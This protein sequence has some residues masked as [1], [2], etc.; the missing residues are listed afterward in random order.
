[1][2]CKERIQISPEIA[3][4]AD[5]INQ[6]LETR[7]HLKTLTVSGKE[8]TV[9]DMEGFDINCCSPVLLNRF[10][11]NYVQERRRI[12][13]SGEAILGHETVDVQF[14]QVKEYFEAAYCRTLKDGHYVLV[15]GG[16][17][18]SP[19]IRQ[20]HKEGFYREIQDVDRLAFEV[21]DPAEPEKESEEV[22]VHN[23]LGIVVKVS[24]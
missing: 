8:E 12:V 9:L 14:L 7:F 24:Y 17:D 2:S 23:I 19:A 1:M 10:G 22:L 18:Q 4:L 20:I 21:T 3:A 11:L 16:Q 5:R 13:E 15:R 6:E